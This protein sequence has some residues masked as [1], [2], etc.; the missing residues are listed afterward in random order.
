VTVFDRRRQPS[1]KANAAVALEVD[2]QGV[3]DYMT[4]LLR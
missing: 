3:I 1:E 4:Q 2:A